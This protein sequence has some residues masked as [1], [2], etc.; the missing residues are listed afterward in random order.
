MLFRE[1]TQ[2]KENASSENGALQTTGLY[3]INWKHKRRN[4]HPEGTQRKSP[5]LRARISST[6]ER[7]LLESN[8]KYQFG[9]FSGYVCLKE[10]EFF[11]N[12]QKDYYMW[13]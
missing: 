2:N 5:I 4:E 1:N 7:N 12:L 11:Q 9:N 6:P 10:K 3:K 13:V 8:Y